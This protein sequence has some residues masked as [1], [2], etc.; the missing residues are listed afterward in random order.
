MTNGWVAG[1]AALREQTKR[2]ISDAVAGLLVYTL[3]GQTSSLGDQ[4]FVERSD[5]TDPDTKQKTQRPVT[6]QEPWGHRGR[7]PK[8]VRALCL[9]FGSSNVVF[10]G[11]A[12]TQAYG[13]Q[14]LDVGEVAVYNVS[15]ALIRLWKDGHLTVDADT[16]KDVVVNGGSAKVGRVGDT[17]DIGTFAFTS[18]PAAGP[19]VSGGTAVLTWTPPG[20]GSPVTIPPSGSDLTGKISSGAPNFKG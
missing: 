14:D 3:T 15:K 7:P 20:G 17:V 19:G 4:D 16:G 9:K 2:W 18:T 13:P 5:G 8:G 11:V 12:P 6:R 1:I 10:I